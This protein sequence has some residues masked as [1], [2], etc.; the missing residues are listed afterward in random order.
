[1]SNEKG[2]SLREFARMMQQ[3]VA[4]G[5][6]YYTPGCWLAAAPVGQDRPDRAAP[7]SPVLLLL[8]PVFIPR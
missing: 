1:M 7:L 2:A 4:A 5:R 8:S 6:P 3:C